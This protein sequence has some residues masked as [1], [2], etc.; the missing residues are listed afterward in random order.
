[1]MMMMRHLATSQ[2]KLRDPSFSR[3]VTIHSCRRQTTDDIRRIMTVVGFRNELQ[4]LLE[5]QEHL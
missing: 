1:M 4:R 5:T 3:F 2:R